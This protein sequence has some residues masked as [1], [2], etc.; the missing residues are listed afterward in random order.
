MENILSKLE[1]KFDKEVRAF[2]DSPI[3]VGLKLLV[4]IFIIKKCWDWLK[5][6]EDTNE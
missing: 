3:K 6:K 2:T 5:S 1:A 4:T